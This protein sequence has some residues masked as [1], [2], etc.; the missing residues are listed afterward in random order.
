MA[1]A[2]HRAALSSAQFT[3][4]TLIGVKNLFIVK[5]T[6]WRVFLILSI[7]FQQ[8]L[9]D[10]LHWPPSAPSTGAVSSEWPPGPRTPLNPLNGIHSSAPLQKLKFGSE[11]L[12]AFGSHKFVCFLSKFAK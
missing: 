1:E 7:S 3:R 2:A 12:F 8:R 10:S 4:T 6:F 5:E 9:L 11:A